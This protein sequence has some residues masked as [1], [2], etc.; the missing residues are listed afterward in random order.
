MLLLPRDFSPNNGEASGAKNGRLNGN[1]VCRVVDGVDFKICMTSS[2]TYSSQHVRYLG[3]C[4]ILGILKGLRL[5]TP[6]F[7]P[8]V[9]GS[10]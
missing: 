8:L 9:L 4:P 6:R 3:P 5:C 7:A 2:I 1:W 10:F